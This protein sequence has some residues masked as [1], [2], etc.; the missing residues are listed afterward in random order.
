MVEWEVEMI[1]L[2]HLKSYGLEPRY[3]EG[4]R[5]DHL[6]WRSRESGAP[7]MLSSLVN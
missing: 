4:R 5:H 3:R 2:N 1:S 6:H 7:A